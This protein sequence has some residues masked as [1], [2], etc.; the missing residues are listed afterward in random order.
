MGVAVRRARAACALHAR[1]VRASCT[2][3]RPARQ[4]H[5]VHSLTFLTRA[6]CSVCAMHAP[7]I[8]PAR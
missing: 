1:A 5:A 6:L 4:Q 2:A 7:C 3:I 8:R